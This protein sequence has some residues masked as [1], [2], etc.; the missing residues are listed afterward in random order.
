MIDRVVFLMKEREITGVQLSGILGLPKNSVAEWKRNSYKPSIE[1]LSKLAELF[2]VSTDYLLGRTDIKEPVNMP[3]K[4]KEPNMQLTNKKENDFMKK[5][6]IGRRIVVDNLLICLNDI[7]YPNLD[8]NQKYIVFPDNRVLEEFMSL[9]EMTQHDLDGYLRI[10]NNEGTDANFPT[11]YKFGKLRMA[12]GKFNETQEFWDML[13]FEEQEYLN[14]ANI[15]E[16]NTFDEFKKEVLA[17]IHEMQTQIN[18]IN[19]NTNALENALAKQA[20]TTMAS[21]LS[22][23]QKIAS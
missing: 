12:S 22:K 17:A 18:V 20:I 4:K 6:H 16:A 10:I 14:V 8:R 7:I 13:V 15:N 9:S 19:A 1:T 2:E 5:R 21:T 11:R 3:G 23:L